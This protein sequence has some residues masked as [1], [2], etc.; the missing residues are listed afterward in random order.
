MFQN[1]TNVFSFVAGSIERNLRKLGPD[2]RVKVK[3]RSGYISYHNSEVKRAYELWE[4]E[5]L[6]MSAIYLQENIFDDGEPLF[7]EAEANA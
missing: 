6:P 7:G 5:D 4:N 2:S 1:P 3:T